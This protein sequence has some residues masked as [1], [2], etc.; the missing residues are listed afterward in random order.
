VVPDKLR[1]RGSHQG[2]NPRCQFYIDIIFIVLQRLV[3][4]IESLDCEI[5][6]VQA[7]NRTDSVTLGQGTQVSQPYMKTREFLPDKTTDEDVRR[8]SSL[9][10]FLTHLLYQHMGPVSPPFWKTAFRYA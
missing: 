2:V 4:A 5:F 7:Q 10:I 9:S 8:V 6:L 3:T 1:Y